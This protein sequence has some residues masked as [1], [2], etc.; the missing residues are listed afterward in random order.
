MNFIGV[1]KSY[2]EVEKNQLV[3]QLKNELRIIKDDNQ[4][5][6]NIDLLIFIMN[7]VEMFFNQKG[8]GSVKEEVVR[9]VLDKFSDTFLN[10]MIPFIVN[11]K[12]LKP[13]TIRR[14][15]FNYFKKKN[16]QRKLRRVL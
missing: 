9:A 16:Y 5:T 15:I 2:K 10:Q 12:L 11:H 8:S 7:L 4:K 14:K 6:D 13:K 1:S 3:A